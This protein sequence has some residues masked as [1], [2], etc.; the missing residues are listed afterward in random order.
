MSLGVS[1]SKWRSCLLAL[2][3]LFAIYHPSLCLCLLVIVLFCSISNKANENDNTTHR[4][5]NTGN[6]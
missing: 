3:E 2:F 6:L 4:F 5:N 1:L